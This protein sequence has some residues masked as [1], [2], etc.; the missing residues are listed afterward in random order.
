VGLHVMIAVYSDQ[1]QRP[2]TRFLPNMD[3]VRPERKR[4]GPITSA[5]SLFL[6]PGRTSAIKRIHMQIGFHVSFKII[7]VGLEVEGSV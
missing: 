2:A 1:Q 3:L 6:V 5:I 4:P 7:S